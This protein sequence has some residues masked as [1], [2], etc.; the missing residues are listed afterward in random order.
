MA[1]DLNGERIPFAYLLRCADGSLYCGWTCDLK[2]RIRAHN[3]GKGAKYTRSR[4]PV[5]LAWAEEQASFTAARK[6]EAQIKKMSRERKED[7]IRARDPG[8][9]KKPSRP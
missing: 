3:A 4:L 8:N 5:T 9:E 6:R 2:R 1:E 7:L